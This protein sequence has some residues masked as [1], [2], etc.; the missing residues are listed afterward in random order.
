MPQN[1]VEATR[2]GQKAAT[3]NLITRANVGTGLLVKITGIGSAE[4]M[5][6]EINLTNAAAD[7]AAGIGIE[8]QGNQGVVYGV[9]GQ[10]WVQTTDTPAATAIGTRI[11]G[12]ASNSGVDDGKCAA[13]MADLSTGIEGTVIIGYRTVSSINYYLVEFNLP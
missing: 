10:F 8:D 5:R 7:I 4:N 12:V 1:K 9:R 11:L 3:G 13:G 2:Q 6:P